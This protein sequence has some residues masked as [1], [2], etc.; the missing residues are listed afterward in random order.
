MMVD[1]KASRFRVAPHFFSVIY[2]DGVS[3]TNITQ[4]V[5]KTERQPTRF[6]FLNGIRYDSFELP[7]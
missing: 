7:F 3:L 2:Q 5:Q 1:D 6:C 4:A